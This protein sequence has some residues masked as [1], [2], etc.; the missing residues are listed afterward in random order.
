LRPDG[1]D[2]ASQ[3]G[4]TTFYLLSFGIPVS[5]GAALDDVADIH[6][7]SGQIDCLENLC[8]KL[9]GRSHERL[10][11]QI[12][13]VARPFSDQHQTGTGVAGTEYDIL[14]ALVKSTPSATI[15]IPANELQGIFGR[16]GLLR[17]RNVPGFVRY[18]KARKAKTFQIP[19]VCLQ[20]AGNV[21]KVLFQAHHQI[22]HPNL[23]I[24]I[25]SSGSGIFPITGEASDARRQGATSE[26]YVQY[27]AR[28]NERRQHSR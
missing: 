11:L 3:K 22:Y 16:T 12:L 17:D 26:A 20:I 27:A 6:L 15:E 4:K 5:R 14:S 24:F 19:D 28:R 1:T 13:L 23:N 8:Q 9:S 2:L 21:G 25:K 7:V 18:G 10:A